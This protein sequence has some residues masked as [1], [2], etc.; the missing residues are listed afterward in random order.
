MKLRKVGCKLGNVRE[1]FRRVCYK[2]GKVRH[3]LERVVAPIIRLPTTL[4][5][6][7]FFEN[8]TILK[9]FPSIYTEI[10]ESRDPP[11]RLQNRVADPQKNKS[12]NNLR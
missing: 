2:L 11:P 6:Y 5:V 1:E 12:S 3:E 10:K 8:R 7:V 9:R 4:P